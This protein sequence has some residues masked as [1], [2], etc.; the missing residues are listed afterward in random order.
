MY[1]VFAEPIHQEFVV[2]L[3]IITSV[4]AIAISFGL[5][6]SLFLGEFALKCPFFLFLKHASWNFFPPFGLS[7]HIFLNIATCPFSHS[8]L[9]PSSITKERYHGNFLACHCVTEVTTCSHDRARLLNM[10]IT[11]ILFNIGWLS[12]AASSFAISSIWFTYGHPHTYSFS[13]IQVLLYLSNNS[14]IYVQ[15]VLDYG[16]YLFSKAFILLFVVLYPL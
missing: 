5:L 4:I 8:S 14:C 15:C 12:F 9:H 16:L 13:P 6:P 7:Y 3:A 2:G 11:C 10:D 1:L